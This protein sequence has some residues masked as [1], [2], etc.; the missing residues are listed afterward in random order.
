MHLRSCTC[1]L[2]LLAVTLFEYGS[3]RIAPIIAAAI[4]LLIIK[5]RKIFLPNTYIG[6]LLLLTLLFVCISINLI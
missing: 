6:T 2:I 5:D 1:I 3:Y 4:L